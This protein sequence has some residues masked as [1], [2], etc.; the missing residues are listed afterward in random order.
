MLHIILAAVAVAALARWP[1]Q[2]RSALVVGAAA[3]ASVLLGAPVAPALTLVAPLLAFLGAALTLAGLAERSGLGERAAA[4][5]AAHARGNTLALYALV[6]ALCA[7]LTAAV[8]LDGA[9]VLMVPLLLA[10]VRRWRI[11]LA[12]LFLGVVAVANVSSIAVP[13]GNPTNLVVI[14]ALGVSPAGFLA[15]MLLPGIAAAALCAIAVAVAERR[16]LASPY[17]APRR[18]RK[19]LSRAERH[20]ARAVAAAALAAW[21][22]P[23]IG[24]AP[25][26]PFAGVVAVA[27]AAR[28]K[29]PRLVLPW[30]VAV[31][32]G[33]LVIV[34][35]ALAL[36]TPAGA[37]PGLPG[38]LAV[39]G[40]VG[41]ASEIANNLPIS[42]DAAA[43]LA[44]PSAYAAGAGLAIGSLATP[45]GS[46]ATL[47]AAEAAGEGAPRA[48]V[49]RTGRLRT[50]A[51]HR[52]AVGR[53]V[54][55]AA[56]RR[57][58][59]MNVVRRQL[60]SP[61][62]RRRSTRRRGD[63]LTS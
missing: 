45:H 44:G 58:A 32:V 54:T 10:L 7:L 5:L 30:R 49:A 48:P 47:I 50:A 33:G 31:Q 3:S 55:A 37:R 36:S 19:P 11:P 1:S 2:T 27:L 63:D 15:H 41:A 21:T 16:A 28:R 20:A 39:A 60:R 26:W 62:R 24:I 9:V 53:R 43:M 6:C 46:L 8:S 13:E 38:L 17:Q 61:P 23:L 51:G 22:A 18:E 42:V 57:A 52:A 59:A 12:P 34:F 29:R 35:H 56:P 4:A 14:D 25:W 40:V